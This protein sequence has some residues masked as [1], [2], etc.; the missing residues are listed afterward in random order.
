M[1]GSAKTKIAREG[2]LTFE[3]HV[4]GEQCSFPL[5]PLFR[6]LNGH[7]GVEA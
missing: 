1:T 6:V 7:D 3:G 2:D 4:A 5:K